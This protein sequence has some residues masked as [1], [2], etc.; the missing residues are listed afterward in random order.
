M[1]RFFCWLGLH[2]WVCVYE[3]AWYGWDYECLR[4]G[5]TKHDNN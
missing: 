1:K 3:N 4:C 5:E 2:R